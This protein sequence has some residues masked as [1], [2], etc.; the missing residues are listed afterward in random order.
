MEAVRTGVNWSTQQLLAACVALM[1]VLLIGG[2]SGYMIRGT[3]V[4]A[5]PSRSVSVAQ[6]H[7]LSA[8]FT[9]PHENAAA[10]QGQTLPG[11]RGLNADSSSGYDSGAAAAATVTRGLNADSESGY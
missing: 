4:P 9:E 7:A 5:N 2:V 10:A 8:P 11:G 1:A 3:A 6:S